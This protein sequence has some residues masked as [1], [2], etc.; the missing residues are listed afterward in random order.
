MCAKVKTLVVNF[1]DCLVVAIAVSVFRSRFK[2][3]RS[4][5]SGEPLVE[6]NVP[7]VS[8]LEID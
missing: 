6:Q 5:H 8:V 7:K 3:V 4:T 1:D 2:A